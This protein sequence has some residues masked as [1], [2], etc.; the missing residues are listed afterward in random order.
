MYSV[1]LAKG[2]QAKSARAPTS[3]TSTAVPTF[4]VALPAGA[5]LALPVSAA[6]LAA[7]AV[8]LAAPGT[9]LTAAELEPFALV[10]GSE[11]PASLGVERRRSYALSAKPYAGAVA[12]AEN[13][14][15]TMEKSMTRRPV[16]P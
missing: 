7:D 4:A 3:P 16:R 2:A 15:G 1:Y 9:P 6:L 12:C 8:L 14:M 13:D 11:P 10:L 5:E